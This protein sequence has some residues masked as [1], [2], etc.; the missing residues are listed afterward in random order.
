MH[1]LRKRQPTVRRLSTVVSGR[2]CHDGNKTCERCCDCHRIELSMERMSDNFRR[3]FQI[4][5]DSMHHYYQKAH[6]YSTAGN[7]RVNRRDLPTKQFRSVP[8]ATRP[9]GVLNRD[10]GSTES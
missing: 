3:G 1:R 10:H 9:T 5:Y 6:H 7:R 8:A 2:E 4:R